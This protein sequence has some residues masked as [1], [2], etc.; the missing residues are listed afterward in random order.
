MKAA[1]VIII[2]IK[3]CLF[4]KGTGLGVVVAK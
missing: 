3:I 2:I 4:V 1:A